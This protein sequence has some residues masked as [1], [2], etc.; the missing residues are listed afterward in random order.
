MAFS[1]SKSFPAGTV[2][3]RFEEIGVAPRPRPERPDRLFR[4]HLQ[5]GPALLHRGQGRHGL[6]LAARRRRRPDHRAGRGRPRTRHHPVGISREPQPGSALAK[7]SAD[8]CCPNCSAPTACRSGRWTTIHAANAAS[9]RGLLREV[10]PARGRHPD[11]GQQRAGPGHG[12]AD[13][14]RPSAPGATRPRRRSDPT[15]ATST[16]P[17]AR[18]HEP[19]RCRHRQPAAGLP[20][21]GQGPAA[22]R[23]RRLP[24]ARPGEHRLEPGAEAAPGPALRDRQPAASSTPR[25]AAARS[26]TAAALSCVSLGVRNQD[27]RSAV[28]AAAAETRRM[29]LY[30]LTDRDGHQPGA[31]LQANLEAEPRRRR[32]DGPEGP[33]RPDARQL[34]CTTAPSIPSRRT[35]ASS[36]RALDR[37][38]PERVLAEF[39]RVWSHANGPLIVL[40]AAQAPPAAEVRKVWLDAEAGPAPAAPAATARPP[41]G[42]YRFRPARRRWRTARAIDDIGASRIEFANGVRVNFK[43]VDNMQDK[44]FIRIRFGAGQQELPAAKM[45]HRHDGRAAAAGRRPRQERLPGHRPALPG[46]QLQPRPRHRPRQLRHGR[47]DPGQRPRHP[48]AADD[49]LPHRPGL[50][51]RSSTPSCRP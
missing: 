3:P 11:R 48:A 27:W 42:L 32:Q 49:R 21:H 16:R 34:H 45:L 35:T 39:H 13:R 37:V 14:Q 41:L 26:S 18:R 17:P 4:H 24:Y 31:A 25:W 23:G 44:V 28:R 19:V 5:P 51:A 29:E 22:G 7:K 9:I 43:S 40:V 46:A 38:T 47:R 15:S 6:Q 30:G 2:L 12:G 20:R 33:R 1:G 10:V 8:S 36:R 50:P